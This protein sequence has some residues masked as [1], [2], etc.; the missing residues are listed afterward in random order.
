MVEGFR[1]EGLELVVSSL[2][3]GVQGFG[4]FKLLLFQLMAPASKLQKQ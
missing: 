1:F 3:L 2:A 4:G